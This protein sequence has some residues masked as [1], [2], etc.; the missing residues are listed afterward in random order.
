ML[1]L[2]GGEALFSP[3]QQFCSPSAAPLARPHSG[4]DAPTHPCQHKAEEACTGQGPY[5]M[6]WDRIGKRHPGFMSGLLLYLL[7]YTPSL[8][9]GEGRLA[10][11]PSPYMASFPLPPP[12]VP[13]LLVRRQLDSWVLVGLRLSPMASCCPSHAALSPGQA[14]LGSLSISS[15][16]GSQAGAAS[17]TLSPSEQLSPAPPLSLPFSLPP[18]RWGEWGVRGWGESSKGEAKARTYAPCCPKGL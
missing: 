5:R 18:T 6:G 4:L 15:A 8:L 3:D 11:I 16:K 9:P 7:H 2:W 1:I 14:H 13:F 17:W 10:G 12:L